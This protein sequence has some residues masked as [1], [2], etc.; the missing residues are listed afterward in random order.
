MEAIGQLTGGIAHGFNN[1]LA[2]VLSSLSLLRRHAT[3][4]QDF[5]RYLSAAEEGAKR[6]A[7]LTQRLLAF[8]R[9]QPLTPETVAVGEMIRELAEMLR[10]T[11]GSNVQLETETAA[12]ATVFVDRNL[13]ESAIV[14]L[15]INGR[16]AMPDGGRLVVGTAM[17]EVD[18]L[19]AQAEAVAPGMYVRIAVT[20]SRTGM[21]PEVLKRAFDPFFTTKD[22]GKGTGLGLSQV[23]RFVRQ[24]KGFIKVE[25][26]LAAVPQ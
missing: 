15:A 23:F 10:R 14:N 26:E 7:G 2:V 22:P 3:S 1:M 11:L 4:G 21:S 5:S 6:A 18:D 16:D 24:S 19:R 20:D 25:S 8:S 12:D 17:F 13:L 9:Q